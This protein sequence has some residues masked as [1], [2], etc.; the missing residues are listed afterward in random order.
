MTYKTIKTKTTYHAIFIMYAII[1]LLHANQ[2]KHYLYYKSNFMSRLPLYTKE[3]APQ[4]TSPLIEKVLKNNGFL[5]NLI[6]VLAASPQA[7]ST[8]LNVGASNATTSLSLAEREVIQLTAARIHGCDFCIAGHTAIVVKGKVLNSEDV[9]ALHYGEALHDK[10]LQAMADFS[11][12]VIATRGAVSDQALKEFLAAG[13]TQQ[14]ALDVV[15]GISLAT[16]CNFANNLAQTDINPELQKYQVGAL[17]QDSKTAA[18]APEGVHVS[19]QLRTCLDD[20][21]DSLDQNSDNKTLLTRFA[22]EGLTKIGISEEFGGHG[23]TA[24]DAVESIASLAESS[25]TASFVLWS[26]RCYTEFL[27]NSDNQ[28]LQEK[29]LPSLLSGELAGAAGLSNAMKFLGGIE[30][31]DITANPTS[32]STEENPRW[33]VNGKL[34]WVTNLAADGFSVAAAVQSTSSELI[35]VFSFRSSEEGVNRGQDL[36]LIALRNSD[37]ASVQLDNVLVSAENRLHTDLSTWLPQIRPQF[38]SFLCGMSI[39]L[40]RTSIAVARE[41]AARRATLKPKIE[42]LHQ[43]LTRDTGLLLHGLENNVFST[44]PAALFKLRIAFANYVKEALDIELQAW[45]GR[46]YLQGQAP[47]FARRWREAAFI[48]VITPSLVQLEL[49]LNGQK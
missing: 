26:H 4:E 41:Q 5:P 20:A 2:L 47:G 43:S 21:A 44:N 40:A 27:V 35:P 38:L 39:G 28:R 11:E 34:P 8:Y 36:E 6:A 29:E 24:A 7:L 37:V 9:L 32:D 46:A 25:L 33:L 49:Q 18:L 30:S 3:S 22:A 17:E 10:K 14:Q 1:N 13:Y 23:G 16:L 12:A 48:P 42:Q 15:L 31:L 19:E 45:G